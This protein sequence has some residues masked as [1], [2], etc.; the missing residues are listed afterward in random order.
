MRTVTVTVLLAA[1]L[2]GCGSKST[3]NAANVYAAN[4]Q[5]EQFRFANAF[6]Q[7]TNQL[8]KSSDPKSDAKAL[9]NAA[10][11]VQVD[12]AALRTVTPPKQVR[13][14]HNQLIAVVSGYG[15]TVSHAAKLV[16]TGSPQDFLHA[17]QLLTTASAKINQ[18]FNT[19]IR[20]INTALD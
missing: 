18:R 14:L 7:A 8:L 15:A 10:Q 3:T 11:A 2:G 1:L 9:T 12:A 6:D 4:V 16:A 17:K 19:I 5:Q 20:R 13:S